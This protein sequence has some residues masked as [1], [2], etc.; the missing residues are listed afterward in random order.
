MSEEHNTDLRRAYF[1]LKA[2]YD[3]ALETI[4][5]LARTI[6][7]MAN[8]S[9]LNSINTNADTAPRGNKFEVGDMVWYTERGEQEAAIISQVSWKDEQPRYEVLMGS[10]RGGN[11]DEVHF[12]RRVTPNEL[13]NRARRILE[14][15]GNTP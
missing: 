2:Q 4:A 9:P 12:K 1:E 13:D 5:S 7:K 15:D 3:T 6:E 10:M 11:F 8:Q 14:L